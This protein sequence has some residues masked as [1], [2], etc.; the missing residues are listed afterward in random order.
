MLDQ[1]LLQPIR[2]ETR[3]PERI[4]T[5]GVHADPVTAPGHVATK[6]QV[7]AGCDPQDKKGLQM[8]EQTVLCRDSAE[9]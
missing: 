3:A 5:T 6:L 7:V 4:G 9:D 2:L 8:G 1:V